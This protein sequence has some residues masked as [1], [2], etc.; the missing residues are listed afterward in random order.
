MAKFWSCLLSK[1]HNPEST[2]ALTF[3]GWVADEFARSGG[4]T[5][6]VILVA[7]GNL[8]VTPQKSTYFHV[9][10]DE[11]DWLQVEAL[12]TGSGVAWDGVVFSSLSAEDGGPVTDDT[13]RAEL[14]LLE[15]RIVADRMTIND[16]HFFDGLGRRMQIEEAQPQ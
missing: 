3:D 2:R 16:A 1:S 8:S 12:L 5:A 10:G 7:I 4:F 13:A 6:L 11:I 9:I 14:R 15:Q